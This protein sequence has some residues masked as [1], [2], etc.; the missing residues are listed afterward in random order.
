[1]F[2]STRSICFIIFRL[3]HI[4]QKFLW[5]VFLL[6]INFSFTSWIQLL[7][8]AILFWYF[9]ILNYFFYFY[10]NKKRIKCYVITSLSTLHNLIRWK[11]NETEH[12]CIK[13]NPRYILKIH[14]I[15]RKLTWSNVSRRGLHKRIY[16]CCYV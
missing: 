12:S 16:F 15:I 1:M 11:M 3:K 13:P 7:N 14:L 4:S 8:C 2:V 9:I 10:I 6:V 5:F